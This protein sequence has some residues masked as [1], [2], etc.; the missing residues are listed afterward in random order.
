[1]RRREPSAPKRSSVSQR[2]R[3]PCSHRP[4]AGA[5]GRWAGGAGARPAG[6]VAHLP[7]LAGGPE[8]GPVPVFRVAQPFSDVL[9][10]VGEHLLAQPLALVFLPLALV[11]RAVPLGVPAVPVHAA[12]VPEAVV[13]VPRRPS[14]LPLPVLEAVD[15]R[16]FVA[17]ARREEAALPMK[18]VA[19]K[20]ADI[21]VGLSPRLGA[22]PIPL[23][24]PPLPCVSVSQHGRGARRATAA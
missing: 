16:A 18:A 9:L 1:M 19:P 8:V 7:R 4:C 23:A 5:P 6:G 3:L 17:P 13:H 20:L 24:S 12:A 2:R 22:L 10:P 11:D 15:E 14:H 21:L